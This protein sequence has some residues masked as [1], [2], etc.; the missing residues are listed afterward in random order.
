MPELDMILVGII[1]VAATAVFVSGKIRID[2]VALCVLVLLFVLDLIGPEQ[3]LYGLANQATVT[4]AAMFILSAGLVRTGLVEWAARQLDRIAGKTELRLMLIV[5]LTAAFL[6]AFIINAAIVAIFIPVAMV[7]ARSR[8]I[9]SSRILI[10][11]SFA[12]QFGGVCTLVGTSTNLI[13]NSYAVSRGMEP[14]GF[15]EFLPLGIAM[16][17][18]GTVYLAAVGHWLLPVRKGEAEQV[19]KYRLVD[20][21]AELQ[22]D[23]KSS[24]IGKTWEESKVGDETKVELANLLRGTRAVSR[25]VRTKIKADDILLLHGNV[26]QIMEIESRYGLKI[27]K[28]ARVK[29]QE[30]STHNMKLS[31]VLVPPDSNLIGRTLKEAVFFRRHKLTVLAIQRRG[32]TL[33]ERL[34]DIKL[35]EN[36]TVLLQGH[37]DDIAHIMNS[38]NAIVTNELTDL[39][40][41]KNRAIIALVVLLAVVVLTTMNIMP[42]MLAAILGAVAMVVT[43]CLNIEEAYKAI[44]WKIIFLLAGVLPLG[45]ALEH[46]GATLWLADH[47]LEPLA[48]NGPVALLAAF[49]FITAVLTEA[50][51]NNA[52]A[53]ILAPI[54]FTTAASLNIDPRPLLV[55]IT[56]AASTSFATPIGYKTNTMIYSPG[57]YRF[58]DFTRIGVPLNLIFWGIAVLLIPLIWPLQ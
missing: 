43:Q 17:G 51:S 38:P 23:E 28:D 5:S 44:D 9:A 14:F 35:K 56:F 40:L 45:L 11:L 48:G 25:P 39:Y 13:V 57:G 54:A 19:D 47:V 16:V 32:R 4:I 12:S 3:V 55:A 30:L 8:K 37:K 41:R 42:I 36:D 34:G 31:E 53:A 52:A 29:D 22:V 58:T 2:I 27:L 10:P 6:S 33:R 7:L 18:A 1:V 46:S 26:E 50:M 15:F 20:Y 21:L 49:Y 24:L